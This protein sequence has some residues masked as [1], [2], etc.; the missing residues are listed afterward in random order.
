MYILVTGGAG[1]I[2]SHTL[3]ELINNGYS[4]VVF[5]NFSNSTLIALERVSEIV[6]SDIIYRVGDIRDLKKLDEVFQEFKFS[7]V[8]HFAGLKSVNESVYD[9]LLYYNNNVFGTLQLLKV[10]NDHCV[11]SLVFSSSATVYGMPDNLPVNETMNLNPATNPYGRSKQVVEGI[12]SDLSAADDSWSIICLRYFNPVGA[13]ESGLIGEDPRGIPNNLMP[14]ITQTV[15]GIRDKLLV[16]GGDYDTHD[17]TGVRDYIHVVDL[18]IGHI[19]AL[20]KVLDDNGI[21]CVNL[22]TGIGYSV[23][24]MIFAFEKVSG[25]KIKYEIVERRVGDLAICF[26]DPTYAFNLLGWSAKYDL[27]KMCE[28]SWRWQNKNPNGFI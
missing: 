7:A 26:S 10:M 13:H 6:K 4:P 28:D 23:L 9:P 5:D 11:K 15:S 8:I 16:Y 1:Y 2:G 12:L 14:F 18:A 25:C 27:F 22:G 24:D 3:I 19:S 20:S 21:W 17:G